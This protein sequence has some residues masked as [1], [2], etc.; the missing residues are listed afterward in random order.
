MDYLNDSVAIHQPNYLPWLGYFYKIYL[1]DHFI[2]HDDVDINLRSF[3]KR[4]LLRKERK[5]I[6]TQWL[7]IPTEKSSDRKISALIIADGEKAVKKHLRKIK[8]IYQESKFFD[9]C[10]SAIENTLLKNIKKETKLADFNIKCIESISHELELNTAF[11]RSSQYSIAANK[12]ELNIELIKTVNGS[13][14]VSG[15][16]AKKYQS[17]EP[18]LESQINLIYSNANEY[19]QVYPYPQGQGPSLMGLSMVDVW[20]N[21]GKDGVLKLFEKM[22]YNL[23]EKSS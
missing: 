12:N 19:L 22:F 3:T 7:I 10:Y 20:M 1:V 4:T 2:F 18:F 15:I 17:K 5:E 16:G 6:E 21:L 8:Y 14:Y 11:Y 13:S 9:E 23:K